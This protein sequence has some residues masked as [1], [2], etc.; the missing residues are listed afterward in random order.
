MLLSSSSVPQ[1]AYL[2]A[3]CSDNS[4]HSSD[5]KSCI[6]V[7]TKKRCEGMDPLTMSDS[8]MVRMKRSF[9]TGGGAGFENTIKC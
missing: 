3:G 6:S 8:S 2:R 5:L 7:S 9:V 1:F 4:N